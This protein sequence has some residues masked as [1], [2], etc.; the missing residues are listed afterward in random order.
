[1]I[2]LTHMQTLILELVHQAVEQLHDAVSLALSYRCQTA[3]EILF[4]Q[5]IHGIADG[6]KGFHRLAVEIIKEQQTEHHHTLGPVKG[7]LGD[8]QQDIEQ[9]AYQHEQKS[10]EPEEPPDA[11]RAQTIRY[12]YPFSYHRSVSDIL[13]FYDKGHPG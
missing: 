7:A 11:Q 1:M 2:L 8:R 10:P 5:Q 13:P 6:L 9:Q 12:R 3:A 4:V